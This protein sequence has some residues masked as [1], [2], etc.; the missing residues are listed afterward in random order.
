MCKCGRIREVKAIKRPWWRSNYNIAIKHWNGRCAEDECAS[1]D[2]G[3]QRSKINKYS[4]GMRELDGLFT[5]GLRTGAVICELLRQLVLKASE[6][7][8]SLQ[9]Q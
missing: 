7:D 2:T 9:L 3:V 6:G 5:D 8:M 1:T 4:M